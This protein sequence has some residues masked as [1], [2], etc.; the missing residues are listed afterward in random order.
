MRLPLLVTGTISV[1]RD[2]DISAFA[3]CAHARVDC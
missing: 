1:A 3:T 2:P